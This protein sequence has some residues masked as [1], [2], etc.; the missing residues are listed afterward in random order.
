LTG[1]TLTDDREGSITLSSATLAPG[2]SATG[3]ASHTVAEGDIVENDP[4]V[5]IAEAT[6][7]PPEGEDVTDEDTASVRL[8]KIT[9]GSITLNKSGLDSTDVAGFTLY[10]SNGAAVTGERLITGNGTVVWGNIP[11]D[12]YKIVETTVPSG[13]SRMADITS[14]VLNSDNKNRTFS[15]TNS[16]STGGGGIEVLGIMELPFTGM[17]P[18]IPISGISAVII[19]LVMVIVS[20]LRRRKYGSTEDK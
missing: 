5:N 18:V 7:T 2:E 4:Y 9:R 8:Y 3:T 15:R 14:I 10:N 1:V 20:L 19:G 6:G 16:K 17:N 12:T 13:Y 11:F